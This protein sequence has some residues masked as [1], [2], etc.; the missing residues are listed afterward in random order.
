[1]ANILTNY[2]VTSQIA[3]HFQAHV[4]K[5]HP[6]INQITTYEVHVSTMYLSELNY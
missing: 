3:H 6:N 1:M 4:I 5:I 2:I